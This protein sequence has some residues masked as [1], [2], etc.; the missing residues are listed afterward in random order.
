MRDRLIT[1]KLNASLSNNL[2]VIHGVP[3]GS[4]LRPTFFSL[5]MAGVERIIS[6]RCKIGLFADDIAF[7][8]SHSDVSKFESNINFTLT[9]AG[10]IS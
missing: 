8:N 6:E 1:G 5:Y 7:W 10:M 9:D 2:K 4:V 3:Q